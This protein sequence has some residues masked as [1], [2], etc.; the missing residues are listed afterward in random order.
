MSEKKE[1]ILK[2]SGPTD[3]G[4]VAYADTEEQARLNFAVALMQRGITTSVVGSI[5]V[6][7]LEE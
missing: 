1:W 3:D 2:L 7:E 4:P 6:V 5:D